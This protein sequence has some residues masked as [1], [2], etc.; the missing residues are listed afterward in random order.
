M[1]AITLELH[2]HCQSQQRSRQKRAREGCG[3]GEERGGRRKRHKHIVGPS[4]NTKQQ[5]REGEER[6]HRKNDSA[7][8]AGVQRSKIKYRDRRETWRNEKERKGAVERERQMKTMS[9]LQ[10]M[11]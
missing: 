11:E 8:D 3:K 10:T 9:G 1:T 2:H 5:M 7:L 6:R 4:T